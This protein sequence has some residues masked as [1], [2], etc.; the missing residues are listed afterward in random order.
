MYQTYKPSGKVSWVCLPL[1]CILLFL[2]I[3]AVSFIYIF[4][5]R[6]SPSVILN[7][8]LYLAAVFL[9]ALFGSRVYLR[10]GKVR[11]LQLAGLSAVLAGIT[12]FY[13]MF[14]CYYLLS[15]GDSSPERLAGLLLDP[16]GLLEAWKGLIEKGFLISTVKGKPLFTLR[17]GFFIAVMAAVLLLTIIALV[18]VYV[19]VAWFPFCEASKKWA[20]S[21]T[22]YLEYI[23]NKEVFIQKLAFGDTSPLRQLDVLREVNCS[24]CEAEL[25]I[26]DQNSD[27]YIT[28]ENKKKAQGGTGADGTV[29]FEEDEIMQLL[30]LD[31]E[32]GEILLAKAASGPEQASARIVTE[33]SA[34]SKIMIYIRMAA[35]AIVQIALSALCFVED[36]SV[37]K[38][39]SN[40]L[41]GYY[42]IISLVI[43]LLSLIGC[44]VK[45][46]VILKNEGSVSFDETRRY[47]VEKQDSP[48]GYKVYYA[49]MA[50]TSILILLFSIRRKL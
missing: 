19:D 21:R 17:G 20:A 39:M 22:I 38:F 25:Y 33:E 32:T 6:H 18:I 31:R 49:A 42:M 36:D 48:A 5:M 34:K 11:N 40:G 24:H 41:V 1:L 29:K 8:V 30:R 23:E 16:A 3:P 26:T 27:F 14:A 13:M 10:P 7:G 50:L 43:N 44:F 37:Q 2:L 35:A 12:F 9:I 47:Q 46:D 28:L 15:A 45:E 4:I